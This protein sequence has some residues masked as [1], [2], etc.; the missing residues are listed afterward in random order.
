MGEDGIEHHRSVYLLQGTSD[1]P[2]LDL[3]EVAKVC[4]ILQSFHKYR[5]IQQL[6]QMGMRILLSKH[7]MVKHTLDSI[8]QTPR[9]LLAF[10]WG[11][12][13]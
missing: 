11:T 4:P 9:L 8:K 3:R 1:G 2:M 13:L 12:A 10:P 7:L 5:C 6:E